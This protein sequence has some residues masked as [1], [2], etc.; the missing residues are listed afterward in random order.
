MKLFS[1]NTKQRDL[2]DKGKKEAHDPQKRNFDL[3]RDLAAMKKLERSQLR[4]ALRELL[5]FSPGNPQLYIKAFID[6][7]LKYESDLQNR[8]TNDRMEFLGDSILGMFVSKY[9]FLHKPDSPVGPLSSLKAHIV[10]RKVSNGIAKELGLDRFFPHTEHVFYSKDSLGNALEAL[11]AA[12]YLDKG[13]RHTEDFINKRIL[14]LYFEKKQESSDFGRNFK[15]E[16]QLWADK[17]SRELKYET[18]SERNNKHTIFIAK[19]IINGKKWGEG[20]GSTKK[21][22]EQNAAQEVLNRIGKIT[23]D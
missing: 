5:G 7:A 6:P 1:R 12:I 19:V 3:D 8:D 11:I 15:G 16:L 4:K 21:T 10:S 2:P 20:S 18:S 9:L 14:P 17:Q 23:P 22:A 13:F